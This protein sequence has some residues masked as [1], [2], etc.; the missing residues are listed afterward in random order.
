MGNMNVFGFLMD[1]ASISH[2]VDG[3]FKIII[4]E[5]GIGGGQP[6]PPG[7]TGPPGLPGSFS[8][9]SDISAL[10]QSKTSPLW[11]YRGILCL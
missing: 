9:V 2:L 5:R 8:G 3:V 1:Q 11:V 7:A 6:G 4:I 10:L